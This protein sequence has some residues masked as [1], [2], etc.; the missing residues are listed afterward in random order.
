M[1]S[2]TSAVT[3]GQTG[4]ISNADYHRATASRS[5]R[6][7]QECTVSGFAGSA[8]VWWASAVENLANIS[9]R[10]QLIV[11]RDDMRAW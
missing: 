11:S 9:I 7:Y 1:R 10:D 3:S 2:F 4:T 5:S 8:I 6:R